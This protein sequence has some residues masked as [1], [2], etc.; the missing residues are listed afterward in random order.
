L[1]STG[2]YQKTA[3]AAVVAQVRVADAIEVLQ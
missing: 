2:D 1:R 3:C